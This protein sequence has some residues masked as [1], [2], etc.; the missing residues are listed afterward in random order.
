MA[1]GTRLWAF[2]DNSISLPM[3][4][5]GKGIGTD[6]YGMTTIDF[7]DVTQV[8]IVN[9][10]TTKPKKDKSSNKSKK[11]KSEGDEPKCHIVLA[12]KRKICGSRQCHI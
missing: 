8:F 1:K 4:E 3:G 7:K 5:A 2:E 10:I 11:D 6:E 9:D 12:G